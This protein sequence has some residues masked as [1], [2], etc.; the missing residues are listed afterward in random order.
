MVK[1]LVAILLCFFLVSLTSCDDNPAAGSSEKF[2]VN[3]QTSWNAA[4]VRYCFKEC[5]SDSNWTTGQ[6][7][8]GTDHWFSLSASGWNGSVE[9]IFNDGQGVFD[10][11]SNQ[12][13]KTTLQN[14]WIQNGTIFDAKPGVH[15]DPITMVQWNGIST[16]VS[17]T[18]TDLKTYNLTTTLKQRN[19]KFCEHKE[20]GKE[21][22]ITEK[23][24]DMILRTNNTLFDALF[25]LS[26][27]EVRED[28]VENIDD[29]GFN[30]G[31]DVPCS[32]FETGLEWHYVWTRDTAYAVDLGLA[33]VDPTRA[34]N[35]LNFKISDRKAKAGGG[36]KQIVQDTGTGGSWPISTD[37]VVW[38]LG[39]YQTL[40]YLDGDE[41]TA[42]LNDA[43][44]AIKNTAEN[45]RKHIYDESD[46]LYTGEES[47]LD[48]R[49]NTYP[50]WTGGD[51]VHIGMSKTLSTNVLHYILLDI[52]SKLA[53]EKGDTE[54]AA[55]LA[56]WR[57]SLK[58]AISAQLFLSEDKLFAAMKT[59]YL[60][61]A[62]IKKFDLLGQSL[63]IL[64]GVT[65][66]TQAQNSIAN[67]PVTE[68]GPPVI[69][70][71]EPSTR[72]YHNRGIWPFVTAY[73]M[74]AAL[75]VENAEAYNNALF[76]LVHGTAFNLS[77]MENLEYSTL[78]NCYYDD[79]QSATQGVQSGPVISSRRQLWSVGAYI[80]L[81]VDGIFGQIASQTG[82]TFEPKISKKVRNTLLAATSTITLKNIKYRGK[83][84]N[85]SVTLPERSDTLVGFYVTNSV[86]LNGEL[87]TG[88]ITPGELKDDG[89]TLEIVMKEGS[90]TGTIT[91]KDCSDEGNCF[92]PHAPVVDSVV[93][94]NGT[95]SVSFSGTGNDSA[96]G[97]N[98]VTYN[99]Y[100]DGTQVATNA[101]SPWRDPDSGDYD[102][103]S[104]C[105]SVTALSAQGNESHIASPNCYWGENYN[106]IEKI[107][108]NGFDQAPDAS[109]HGRA[110]FADWGYP[111][112][113]LTVSSF[114][115]QQ[116]GTYLM[117][118]EYSNSRPINTGITGCFKTVEIWDGGTLV[119]EDGAMMPHIG[120]DNWDTW[121]DSS[122]IKADLD[123]SKS[124]KIVI[125]DLFNMS[126][127][128]HFTIYTSG[129]GGGDDIYNRAN[130]GGL[131]FLFK[132]K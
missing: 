57:D 88:E 95:L 58:T 128:D 117:Q 130:I 50:V 44:E 83:I 118:I 2:T 98:A 113:E 52:G 86:R 91:L 60:N 3:Y 76:S 121:K 90:T 73:A 36:N 43:Y 102:S 11:N 68:A 40:K 23:S 7:T 66:L 46:G 54:T 17:A 104:H 42:F 107:D 77:N 97:I 89:N 70:P 82:I 72:I 49:E 80:S 24:G 48:W 87:K 127:F 96:Y 35:S 106:R 111:D 109:D 33:M 38:A 71:Q 110:H 59:T 21:R 129:A 67:Y 131:K 32:C 122:F 19:G 120:S 81:V 101:T 9:M 115:P 47:F 79:R 64:G 100:R 114:S 20:D 1:N 53:T 116:T 39:A 74:R 119:A 132:K 125:K 51:T 124:Y 30:N 103:V 6:M 5:A 92:A 126:Y 55:K 22:S 34:K 16:T 18:G 63:A 69:W 108:A 105:Y 28:S 78:S 37:R 93:P 94:D 99:I 4:Y 13:Y 25:A 27:E 56:G 31:K 41:R 14:S 112:Q 8:A 15:I 26:L 75:Q 12:N 29:W 61:D 85:I 123:S 10:T 62:P 45:D 84:I 65:T